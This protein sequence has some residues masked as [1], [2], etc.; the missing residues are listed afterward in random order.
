MNE[1]TLYARKDCHLCDLVQ[2][3]LN[4]LQSIIP[5]HLTIID[6][7]GDLKLR[8]QYG[9]NVPVVQIGPYKLSAQS[10]EGS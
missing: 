6:I 5:H 1:V 2:I 8:S 4:E 9:F 7:D 3:D 10:E